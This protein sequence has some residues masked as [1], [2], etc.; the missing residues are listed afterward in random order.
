MSTETELHRALNSA[1]D[2]VAGLPRQLSCLS[3]FCTIGVEAAD[4]STRAGHAACMSGPEREE[5]DHEDEEEEMR[6]G[7]RI[8]TALA[9][10]LARCLNLVEAL[11]LDAAGM[12]PAGLA[13]EASLAAASS[14]CERLVQAAGDSAALCAAVSSSWKG[15]RDE[16]LGWIRKRLTAEDTHLRRAVRFARSVLDGDVPHEIARRMCGAPGPR[17]TRGSRGGPKGESISEDAV[18][19]ARMEALA[20]LRIVPTMALD[21]VGPPAAPGLVVPVA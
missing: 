14:A 16:M 11:S 17:T 18:A 3:P 5:D 10:P 7:D 15:L 2:A 9:R 13:R 8:G 6:A 21:G 4:F 20:G 19:S 12:P 1:R